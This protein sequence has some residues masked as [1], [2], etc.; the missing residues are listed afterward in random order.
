M[1]SKYVKEL[2]RIADQLQHD[3][4]PVSATTCRESA[5]RMERMEL[6]IVEH[7]MGEEE[8]SDADA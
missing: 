7:A 4:Y 5:E 1:A 3:G 8:S 6:L 2:H